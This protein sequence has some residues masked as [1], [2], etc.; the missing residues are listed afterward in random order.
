MKECVFLTIITGTELSQIQ[1]KVV[2]SAT[3]PIISRQPELSPY[4]PYLVKIKYVSGFL[5]LKN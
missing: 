3:D 5:I 2:T 4:I 1:L